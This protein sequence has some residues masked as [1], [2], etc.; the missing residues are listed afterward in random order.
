[1]LELMYDD[2]RRWSFPFQQYVQLTMAEV[3]RQQPDQN[4]VTDANDVTV[5]M[6]ERSLF[7]ARHCFVE[8]LAENQMITPPEMIIYDE[9]YKFLVAQDFCKIDLIVYLKSSPQTCHERIQKRCRPEERKIPLSYLEQLHERHEK[10]LNDEHSINQ[11]PAPVLTLS[12]NYTDVN[13]L[14]EICEKAKP[15]LFGEKPISCS[16]AL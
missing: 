13:S 6:M 11:L 16:L 3:H 15:Y 14:N 8:N 7:S 1:M 5:K 4:N 12:N 9:W 10:W 2:P